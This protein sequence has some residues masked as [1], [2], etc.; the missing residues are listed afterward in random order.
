MTILRKVLCL[1]L[2]F[3]FL[4][5]SVCFAEESKADWQYVF[6][7]NEVAY[8]VDMA[9]VRFIDKTILFWVL[10]DKKDSPTLVL[11]YLA[12]KSSDMTWRVEEASVHERKTQ[13]LISQLSQPSEWKPMGTG[14]VVTV[15]SVYVA[16]HISSSK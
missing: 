9:N 4:F 6:S 12:V 10:A 13:K 11:A 3:G 1:V 7:R 15:I 5:G 8:S 14:D 2:I 16:D